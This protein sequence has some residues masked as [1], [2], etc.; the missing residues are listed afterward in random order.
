MVEIKICGVTRV[1]D[2]VACVDAGADALGLNFW[3]GTPRCIDVPTARAIVDEVGHRVELVGVF[4]DATLA[5]I[6]DV[7]AATGI[8]W[9]QL[10]GAEPPEMVAALGPK[11]YKALRVGETS[12]REEAR[13]YPGERLLLDA[14]APGMPGGTGKTFDWRLAAELAKARH[15]T[16][17]GGLRVENV[18]DAIAAV[19]PARVDVASGVETRPG[20]KDPERVRAFVRAVRSTT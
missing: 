4:V 1:D 19:G 15:L 10:H 6:G 14:L 13:A 5:E 2:A 9:V 20:H 11:A 3:P 16:L 18:A 8:A 12:V 7:R 17:A